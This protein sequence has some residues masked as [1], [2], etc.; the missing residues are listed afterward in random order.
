MDD[1]ITSISAKRGSEG[2]SLLVGKPFAERCDDENT[3]RQRQHQSRFVRFK[4]AKPAS[5]TR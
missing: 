3:Q 4:P 2:V 1:K 5:S